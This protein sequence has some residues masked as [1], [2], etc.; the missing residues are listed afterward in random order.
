VISF[1]FFFLCGRRGDCKKKDGSMRFKK[2]HGI[3]IFLNNSPL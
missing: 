2:P 3:E 1:F